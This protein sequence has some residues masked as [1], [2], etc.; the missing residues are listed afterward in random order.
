MVM[1]TAQDY[2]NDKPHLLSQANNALSLSNREGSDA[3]FSEDEIWPYGEAAQQSIDESLQPLAVHIRESNLAVVA[4]FS[5]VQEMEG[6]QPL[7]LLTLNEMSSA[8]DKAAA[9]EQK[10]GIATDIV[11]ATIENTKGVPELLHKASTEL[12]IY[13]D[14]SNTTLDFTQ[15]QEQLIKNAKIK[16]DDFFTEEPGHPIAHKTN[17]LAEKA[18]RASQMTREARN[19]H[20]ADPNEDRMDSRL[21]QNLSGNIQ[22]SLALLGSALDKPLDQFAAIIKDAAQAVTESDLQY[23]QGLNDRLMQSLDTHRAASGLRVDIRAHAFD[24]HYDVRT[25]YKSQGT[26]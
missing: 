12:C 13:I 15:E 18:S 19:I 11:K 21:I 25:Y 8:R 10:F 9:A 23:L 22:A 4:A 17:K 26:T 24:I 14:R 1:K 20:S 5:A 2:L 16:I 7:R 6:I 3:I